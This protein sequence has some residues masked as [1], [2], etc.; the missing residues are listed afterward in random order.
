MAKKHRKFADDGWA[1]WI[2][3][4]DTSTIYINHWLN[5]KGK[6]YVDV[7][8]Q[9]RSVKVSKRLQLYVPFAVSPQE[10]ED[11]SLLF[12]DRKILQ[13]TF[14]SACIIDF[15]KNEHTSEIAYNGKTVDIAHI[16]TLQVQ[17]AALSGGTLLI[18]DLEKLHPF[19]AN[20]ELYLIWRMPHKSLNEIFKPRIN[21]GNIL[22][23]LR[24]LVTTP[25]ISEK[26]GYSIRINE[27]RLLPEEITK[28]GAFHRQKMKNAVITISID[29]SYELNDGGCYRIR[30]LEE[31][32]YNE[33]L[34]KSYP[35]EGVITYQWQQTRDDNLQGHFNFY[36]SITKNAVSRSSMF[37]YML[38]L[39]AITVAGEIV[40]TL[41]QALIGLNI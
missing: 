1:V 2:D 4:D 31:N 12:K 26:F 17:T 40:A 10:I 28:I 35:R 8:I 22:D 41:V 23:R 21:V 29:E 36:Y 39:L 11:V 6:S 25:V 19:L 38:L 18:V 34:P 7:A 27:A 5:P 16:S 30:R 24:D 33:Y 15:M 37:L 13:A 32:L 3:G 20:D 14:S 9:I